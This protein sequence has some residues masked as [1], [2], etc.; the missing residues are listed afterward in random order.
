MCTVCEVPLTPPRPGHGQDRT[1][2]PAGQSLLAEGPPAP[3]QLPA[4]TSHTALRRPPPAL[5]TPGHA[6]RDVTCPVTSPTNA[7]PPCASTALSPGWPQPPPHAHSPGAG[8]SREPNGRWS[9]GGLYPQ[10]KRYRHRYS[11]T[12]RCA[13]QGRGP[14]AVH[15]K[16]HDSGEVGS[17]TIVGASGA[18]TGHALSTSLLGARRGLR[19]VWPG[20]RAPP[21][22]SALTGLS[23]CRKPHRSAC[24]LCVCL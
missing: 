1:G 5:P 16:V 14:P 4:W 13:E 17:R 21:P 18:G 23:L 15:P 11:K 22:L 3:E 24:Q 6:V 8:G 2:V 19:R 7:G 9:R 10:L 20:G 12:S